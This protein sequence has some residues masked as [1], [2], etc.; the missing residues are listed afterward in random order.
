MVSG[1]LICELTKSDDGRDAGEIG[2]ADALRD[3]QTG[4]GDTGD[5][6]GFE[7]VEGVARSPF[8]EGDEVFEPEE[9][10]GS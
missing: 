4:D 5:E 1:S 6:V 8:E 9:D 2:I 7:E 10:L 3:G